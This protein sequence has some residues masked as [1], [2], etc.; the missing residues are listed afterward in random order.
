MQRR[1]TVITVQDAADQLLTTP[2]VVLNEIQAGRLKGFQVGGEWRT[3]EE[4]LSSF[5]EG[6]SGEPTEAEVAVGRAARN[7]P[8]PGETSASPAQIDFSGTKWEQAEPFE[9]KWPDSSLEPQDEVYRGTVQVG[10]R[11]VPILIA[12]TNREAA[13]QMRR[14]A[15]VFW[16]DKNPALYPLVE[17]VGGNDFESSGTMASVIK[18]PPTDTGAGRHVR[19]GEQL[20]ALYQSIPPEVLG[21]YTDIV[22]GPR[23]ARSICVV[24]QKDNLNLM[25]QHGIIRL[26]QKNRL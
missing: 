18:H 1:F 8:Q 7:E 6:G 4:A 19:P 12:F 9:F 3:T 21:V 24:A 10:Q 22:A 15:T 14:R 2:D 25:A 16:G 17:F 5:I 26:L 20:P 23:A 11:Q 13:G